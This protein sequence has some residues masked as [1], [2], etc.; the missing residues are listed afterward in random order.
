MRPPFGE[1]HR[2]QPSLVPVDSLDEAVSHVNLNGSHHTDVIVTADDMV[3]R[4]FAKAVESACVFQNCSTRFS[5]SYAF[6]LGSQ[7]GMETKRTMQRG[8][9]GIEGLMTS[10]WVLKGK[11]HVT[12]VDAPLLVNPPLRTPPC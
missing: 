11:G 12:T 2:E 9:V 5:D 1:G 6:G 4:T 10:K 3:A 8:P 7:V